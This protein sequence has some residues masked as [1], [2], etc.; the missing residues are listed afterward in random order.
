[1]LEVAGA[2][3]PEA[4]SSSESFTTN[5]STSGARHHHLS[6]CAVT[7]AGL[8]GQLLGA[9]L[10]HEKPELEHRKSELLQKEEGLKVELADLEKQ[11]LESLADASGDI[12]ENQPL[13]QSLDGAKEK[14]LTISEALAESNRLQVDLDQQREMYRGLATLGSK[15]F[16]L[17]RELRHM[18]HMY[19][20]SLES[21]MMLF[22]KVLK[23]SFSTDS[24][25]EK[26]QQLGNQLKVMVLFYVSRSLF[27][28][29][30]LTF[31]MYLV[32]TA[33]T[34]ANRAGL[35][36]QARRFGNA[37]ELLRS[38]TGTVAF[39]PMLGVLFIA[40]RMRI[41]QIDRE[42]KAEHFWLPACCWICTGSVLYLQ[43]QQHH[44]FV[45]RERKIW[46]IAFLN[47]Y[48]VPSNSFAWMCTSTPASG[49]AYTMQL[50]K[51]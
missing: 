34:Y 10:Q 42:E 20:F 4:D 41:F 15:I 36:G 9:T 29:D 1:M 16:I 43:T 2:T 33:A 24:V 17:V 13:L 5:S 37:Q 14:A 19:R 44:L 8:E 51:V 28:S 22:N 3:L 31:G 6:G 39:A 50:S 18:D 32:R 38:A 21:F 48:L 26:L 25:E 11:L 27:K 40:A 30:R 47:L 7:R 46:S 49:S 23:M 35:L 12:L 45:C